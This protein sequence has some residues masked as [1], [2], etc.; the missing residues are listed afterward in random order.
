MVMAMRKLSTGSTL[1]NLALADDPNG[2]LLAGKYYLLVGDSASGKT[3]FAMT[4]FAE[5]AHNK[6]FA[7]YRLI[8]DNTEDGCLL[9][10]EKFFGRVVA[11]R[12]EAPA[13]DES[14]GAVYSNTVEEFY[15]HVDDAIRVGKPFIY[16]LDSMDALTS[17]PSDQKFDEQ[18]TAAR[19]GKVTAGSY[20]DGKAKINS[21]RLRKVLAGVRDTGSILIIVSQTR[22][23]LGFGFEKKTRS[24]GRALRFYATAEI[25]TSIVKRL[26]RTVAG[27]DREMGVRVACEVKKNRI[28]GKLAKVEVDIYP[29]YGIDDLGSCVDFLIEEGVWKVYK[30]TITVGALGL[31]GSREKI[32]QEIEAKGLE[33]RVRTI[34]GHHWKDVQDACALKR[35]PRFE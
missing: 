3:F 20:G 4:C 14:G 25:W 32:L 29:S 15:F 30:K 8:Y 17:D 11:E 1:L 27:K 24:G 18:K 9:D 22:D 35:K 12:T 10:L 21:E 23:N 33:D 2:A 5:A 6:R 16:V 31:Q 28:T 26:K 13:T 7:N 34:A 19:A